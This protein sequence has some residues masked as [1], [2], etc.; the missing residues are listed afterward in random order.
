M[1]WIVANWQG[2]LAAVTGVIAAASAIAALTPT[3]KDD[4]I[5]S[6]IRGLIDLLALN[7]LNAKKK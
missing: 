3:P 7:V 2:V 4:A 6:K 1:E 5:L